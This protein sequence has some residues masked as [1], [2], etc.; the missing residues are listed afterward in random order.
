VDGDGAAFDASLA[1]IGPALMAVIRA[2]AP[3]PEQTRPSSIR[4]T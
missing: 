1:A 4:Q 2:S 3:V